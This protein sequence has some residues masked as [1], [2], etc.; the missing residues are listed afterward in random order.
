MRSYSYS[1]Y[2]RPAAYS[3]A[4]NLNTVSTIIFVI[5]IIAAIF[6]YFI[7][8]NPKNEKKLTGFKNWL[9]NFLSFRILF[10]EAFCKIIYMASAI[11]ITVVGVVMFFYGFSE[12]SLFL[13]G[14]LVIIL[15]NIILRILFEYSL[16]FIMLFK[17]TGD[18]RKKLI[19]PESLDNDNTFEG[20]YSAFDSLKN[21][22][23][24]RA[25]NYIEA[26]KT[27]QP[28]SENQNQA[29]KVSLQKNCKNC[30]TPLPEGSDFCPNCGIKQNN[31]QQ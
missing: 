1:S 9:Y 28:S 16:V 29:Q 21:K 18:I 24:D 12:V 2:S 11:T 20:G 17:N 27:P 7:F 6:V 23:A 8:L 5:A 25:A 13:A 15:G 22:V 19:D 3:L 10:I 26:N 14:L 30:N 31:T 4:E